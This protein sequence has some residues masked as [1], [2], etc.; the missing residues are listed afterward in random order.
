MALDHIGRGPKSAIATAI[1]EGKI[2]AG[3]VVL[4]KTT[5]TEKGEELVF[6]ERDNSQVV[7]TPRTQNDIEVMGVNLSDCVA[8][9]KVIPAGTSLEEFI[10]Q[11]VQK[12]IAATYKAPTIAIANNDGQKNEVVETGT[13]V[14]V[15]VKSTFTA[16]DAGAI[17]SHVVKRGTTEVATGTE[18][19]LEH[20]EEFVVVD[21]ATHFA[22]TVAYGEG[23]VKNDNF[24]DASPTGHIT[25]GSKTSSNYTITGAR[26][27]FFGTAA[28]ELP[29]V[30]SPYIRGLAKNKLNPAAGETLSITV[31]EGERHIIVALPSTRTLKQVTYVDLGDKGML[32]KFTKSTVSVQAAD[33]TDTNANNYNVYVY[34]MASG[35]AAA[36]NFDFLLA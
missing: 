16:N 26:R 35:A 13:T 27:A 7:V 18:A 36:M 15:K 20:E 23:A 10:K 24:G 34:T 29:T 9:K 25:A 4:T 33:L 5:E 17:S 8:D 3:D 22:S 28:G 14:T 1:S 32:D 19:T 12:R 31:A 30:N 21:G 6:I 2:G 11:L